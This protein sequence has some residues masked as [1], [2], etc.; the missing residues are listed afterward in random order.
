MTLEEKVA[1]Y[2]D[3]GKKIEELERLK[4]NIV[5][6]ILELIPKETKTI[7]VA[8]Y[9]VKRVRRLSIL[10]SLENAKLFNAVKVQT[11][12]DKEKIKELFEQGQQI[13]DVTEYEYIQVSSLVKEQPVETV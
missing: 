12:V 10:T 2:K 7:H 13:P 9:S 4:K 5:R 1:A 11:V 6:E 8:N 3:L